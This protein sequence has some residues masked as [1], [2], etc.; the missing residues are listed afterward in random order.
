MPSLVI[1]SGVGCQRTLSLVHGRV[2]SPVQL[3]HLALGVILDDL[4]ALYSRR[5]RCWERTRR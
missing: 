3:L 2:F 5:R 1:L 4:I